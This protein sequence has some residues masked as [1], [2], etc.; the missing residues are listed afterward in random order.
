MDTLSRRL[1]YG[2]TSTGRRV[3]PTEADILTFEVLHRHGPLP[4]TF[5][6]QFTRHVRRSEGRTKERLGHLYHE[7][8]TP[9][10]GPYLD[11]P[12]QQ[13]QSMNAR[14]QPAVSETTQFAEQVLRE[15]GL[16]GEIAQPQM[17]AQFAHR[18][19]IA[20]ITASIELAIQEDPTL[21]FISEQEILARS[22]NK[23]LEIPCTISY[24]NPRT[25]KRQTLDKPLIPDAVFGI[26]Y[27]GAGYRFFMLEA[28]RNHEPVRRADLGETSY[29]RK[30]LQY[31]E[32]IEKGRY[33]EHF[34]MKAGMLVLN[35]TTN[36]QHMHNIVDLVGEVTGGKGSPYLLFKTMPQFGKYLTVPPVT[37]ELLTQAWLRSNFDGLLIG[38]AT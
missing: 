25:R 37:P 24:A 17:R 8:N 21:R 28:D 6:H 14:Y 5:I 3:V 7:D 22:P 35:V 38:K 31:R 1:R 34:G 13:W 9:H 26:E 19:M 2:R 32:V 12:W 18:F 29:L 4:S 11:R 23:T 33:K 16:L 27:A 10:G 20:C 15:R 36:F 30:I